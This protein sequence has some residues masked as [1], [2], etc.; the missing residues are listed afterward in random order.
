L[1]Q[2][3]SFLL[4]DKNNTPLTP[5]VLWPDL[6]DE[7]LDSAVINLWKHPKFTATTG[8]GIDVAPGFCV[9][10]LKWFQKHQPD[11]W[12]RTH[13]IMTISDYFTFVLAGHFLGDAGTASLLGIS[14]HISTAHLKASMASRFQVP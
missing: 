9:A 7:S 11:I 3:N 1:S 12:A 13:R 4:L 8:L 5:L 2:A 10:K 14:G 6:R